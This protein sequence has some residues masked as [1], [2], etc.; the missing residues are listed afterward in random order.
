MTALTADRLRE[1][2]TY[3]PETGVFR[4]KVRTS[5]RV[6]VGEVAGYLRDGY[7]F[8]TIDGRKYRA[9][10][11]AWLYMYGVWPAELDHVNGDRADNRISNLREATRTQNNANTPIRKNNTSGVKGVCW[12][13]RKRKWMAQIRV[14]G[15]QRF[16]GYY[17]TTEEAGEAYAAAA[18]RYFGEFA[19]VA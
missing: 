10:R 13:K 1:V 5:I 16:L 8:I 11:L 3:D 18:A 6:T 17:E 15:V 12:D 7:R 19:R 14:R 2:L 4:W 9:H